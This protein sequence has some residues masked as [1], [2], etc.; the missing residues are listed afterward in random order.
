MTNHSLL[1]D[2]ERNIAVITARSGSKG[3]TDKNIRKLNGIPLLA[4]SIIEAEK[5]RKFSKIFVSTDSWEYAGIAEQFGADASFLRSVRNSSD[6]AGSWDAVRE[7]IGKFEDKGEFFD[8]VMLLQ[9]TSPLR[10]ADD[11]IASF[12][13]MKEK[14]AESVIGVTETEHS[15]LWCNTLPE[16][17]SMDYF[18]NEKFSGVPRQFLP[19]YYRINGAVYLLKKRELYR[20]RM[21]A[22]GC[23][24]YIMPQE[25]SVDIDTEMDFLY[26][27]MLLK[28]RKLDDGI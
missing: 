4:Y 24:A 8:N 20:D 18:R 28:N 26:A 14:G 2:R 11:I 10:E 19:K 15:P 9:P 23:Y 27:E 21:F 7:V 12:E 22:E 13:L 5:S 6:S 16:T 1:H 17:L 25:R 3:V